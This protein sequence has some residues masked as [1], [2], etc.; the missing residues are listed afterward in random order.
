MDKGG[1]G[2]IAW[3]SSDY[4]RLQGNYTGGKRSMKERLFT[5]EG[6]IEHSLG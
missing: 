6:A 5:P 2:N 1:K 4:I 3:K